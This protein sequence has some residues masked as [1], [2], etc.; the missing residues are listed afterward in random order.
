MKAYDV[1]IVGGGLIGG[2]IAFELA[3]EKMS[4]A[5]LDRQKPGRE[6]S[7]A[8]AGMLSPGPHSPEDETLVPFAKESLRIYPE[9]IAAV[10]EASQKN[11][12]FLR[13]GTLEIFHGAEGINE[14]DRFVTLYRR[15]GLRAEPITIEAAGKMEE[16]LEP[17]ARAAAWLEDEATV[18]PRLLME[19]VLAGAMGRNVS[20]RP[21]SGVTSLLIEGERCT[22]VAVGGDRFA[23]K[24]VVL[25]AGCYTTQIVTTFHELARFAPTRP[26]RGQM[27][28]LRHQDIRMRRVLRSER[29]YLV[30]R[31][32]GRIIAG[33]TLEEAGF[34][35]RVT[36]GGIQ[37]I[38]GA[39]LELV[40]ALAGSEILET[41][42]GLRPG[43]P[44]NLPILGPTEVEG[45]LV[46]TGHYR[47]GILLA[48]ATAKAV[49]NWITAGHTELPVAPFSPS[50]FKEG[51]RKAAAKKNAAAIPDGD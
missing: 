7:W 23:A 43:T 20:V 15:L 37:K 1:A 39:A 35:K 2:S 10:E 14:R 9:F 45:L 3:A 51:S 33:S 5:L 24:F 42:S 50:R 8:A 29:G 26:V 41:W 30:P 38:L 34:D 36:L 21:D 32:D 22:G 47:N 44:D 27:V 19:A 16:S 25:A 49:K 11:T 40:P 17:A 18:D 46:A 4:V 48:P 28:A 31:P 12:P 13:E 6:A